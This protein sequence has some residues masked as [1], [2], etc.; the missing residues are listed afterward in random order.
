MKRSIKALAVLVLAVGAFFISGAWL[1]GLP[2]GTTVAGADV[3][4]MSRAAAVATA[5]VRIRERLKDKELVICAGEHTYRFTYPEFDFTDDLPELVASIRRRGAYSPRVCVRLNGARR[6]AENICSRLDRALREP[7]ARFFRQGPPFAYDEGCDGAQGDRAA[8][9]ADI[10]RSLNGDFCAV[11]VRVRPLARKKSIGDVKRETSLLCS[12]TTYFDAANVPRAANIALAASKLNGSVLEPGQTFSF[13]GAVGPRTEERGFVSA[14]IISGGRFTDGVGGGVCQ[15]STTLYNAALLSGLKIEEYHPHS[16][17][18]GYVAPSRDAMVSGTSCDLK[19]ANCGRLPVYIRAEVC[20][21]AVT[22]RIYGLPDGV[23]RSFLSRV[24]GSLPRP[25]DVVEEGEEAL[26][27][28]GCE[29]TVSEGYL[30]EVKGGVRRERLV[31]RDRYAGV[32]A[33]RRAPRGGDAPAE[34]GQ[35]EQKS[36]GA[37]AILGG[38]NNCLLAC[39]MI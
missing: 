1:S 35:A 16:L 34:D 2:R 26:L 22:C 33:V 27:S 7:C 5:R 24:T 3:G 9:L 10:R 28:P 14:K 21:G 29:G 32:P 37:A 25:A 31:R 20:G 11:K 8:L 36:P 39:Y 13:N 12:F 19:F 23:E 17:R 18:V 30:V 6:I 4:G 15:V 38:P